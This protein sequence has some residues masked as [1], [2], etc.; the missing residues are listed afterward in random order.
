[1]GNKT[2]TINVRVAPE[3]KQEADRLFADLGMNTANAI[4]I[5]LRQALRVGGI[6][7]A[8]AQNIPNRETVAAIEEG[9]DLVKS[10]KARFATSDEMFKDLGV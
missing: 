6:P 1:M 2:A 10:K 7:F 3:I 5:F 4:N 9:R 8:V